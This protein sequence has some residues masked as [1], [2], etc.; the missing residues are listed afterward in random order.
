VGRCKRIAQIALVLVLYTFMPAVTC[1]APP[2]PS[3]V[4]LYVFDCGTLHIADL[5]RF[6]LKKEE[7]RTSDLSVACFLIV[8]PKGTLIWDVGA[9]PDA[10]WKPTGA[11]V[12]HHIVLPDS[13]ER[14][15][16]MTKPLLTQLA[17]VGYAP[18]DITYL[19]LSHYHYDHSANANAFASSTWLVRQEERQAMFAQQSPGVTQPT[20]YAALKRSRTLVI[21]SDEYDVFGDGNVIIKSAGGHT[22]GHQMVYVNLAK[23]GP[24]LLSGDLWHYPEERTLNRVPTFDFDREQTRATRVL[25]EAYLKKT[26]AQLWIQHDFTANAILKKSPQYYE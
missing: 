14:D 2:P 15:V 26:G 24:V 7:V 12:T 1:A 6:E 3:S 23:T 19:A 11:T 10:D 17:E 5:G 18:S 16:D 20:T 13:G 21:A 8:D 25:I 9:V 4:Q 22:P